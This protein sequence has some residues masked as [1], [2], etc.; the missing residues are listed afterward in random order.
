MIAIS[1]ATLEGTHLHDTHDTRDALPHRCSR[2]ATDWWC[3]LSAGRE[4]ALGCCAG[5][6][7]I[8]IILAESERSVQL[9]NNFVLT[10][11]LSEE[12]LSYYFQKKVFC[13]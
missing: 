2:A 4:A 5:F 7:Y 9:T 10:I 11:V 12:M 8:V 6:K 3:H 13:F 1:S